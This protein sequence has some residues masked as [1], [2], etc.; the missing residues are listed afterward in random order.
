MLFQMENDAIEKRLVELFEKAFEEGSKRKRYPPVI[1]RQD[2]MIILE[3]KDTKFNEISNRNDFQFVKI[4][5]CT[6]KY[7]YNNLLKWIDG[8]KRKNRND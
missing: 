6:G 2:A 5:G 7:S 4:D 8:E 1:T 3:V